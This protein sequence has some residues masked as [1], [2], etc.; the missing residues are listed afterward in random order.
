MTI[1]SMKERLSQKDHLIG[2]FVFSTDPQIPMIMAEAGFDFAVIDTEHGLNDVRT[3]QHHVLA[4]QAANLG[5]IVRLGP[6]TLA[7]TPRLLDSGVDALLFPHLGLS[8]SGSQEAIRSTK[9][10]PDGDRP[11]CSGVASAGYGLSNFADRTRLSNNRVLNV[12][13][14]ED[15]EVF[16]NIDQVLD[17]L[18]VDWVLPGPGDL[19][20]SLGLHGQ[21]THPDVV[22]AVET[23]MLSAKRRR[24]IPGAYV[25][26]ADELPAWKAA[27]ARFFVFS[28]DYKIFAKAYKTAIGE[29]HKALDGISSSTE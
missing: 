2:G 4:C 8:G 24:F 3:V 15:K 11:T 17:N 6:S 13:L 29:C 19:A 22:N 9:Y 18:D 5:C 20:S 28:I 1:L 21:L 25:N 12:G 27:G 23:I 16:E 10:W 14:I 26:S 7:D